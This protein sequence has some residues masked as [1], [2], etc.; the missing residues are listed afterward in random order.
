MGW[1]ARYSYGEYATRAES[2]SSGQVPTQ[3]AIRL[4]ASGGVQAMPAW[5]INLTTPPKTIHAVTA[6][7]F[8]LKVFLFVLA[9]SFNCL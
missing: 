8:E 2:S 6:E 3:I 4:F 1:V 7:G 5:A 9:Y